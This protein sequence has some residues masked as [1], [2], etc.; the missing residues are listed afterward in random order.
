[1]LLNSSILIEKFNLIIVFIKNKPNSSTQ[2]N[3]VAFLGS[4]CNYTE[5]TQQ[6]R[7]EVFNVLK[8]YKVYKRVNLL[9]ENNN[10]VFCYFF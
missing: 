5:F 3:L 8:Q 7:F 6:E 4:L 10:K 2:I 9:L 1:M